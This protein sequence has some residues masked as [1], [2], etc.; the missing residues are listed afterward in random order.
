MSSSP[1]V[2]AV[3]PVAIAKKSAV[4]KAKPTHPSF[5]IMITEGIRKMAD[6]TGSSKQ[7]ISKFI[8]SNYQVDLSNKLMSKH[9]RL[10][11]VA[12]A[13]SGHF[14][15][16]KGTGASGSFK[17][18]DA[19]KSAAKKEKEATKPKKEAATATKKVIKKKPTAVASI[20]KFVKVKVVVV[21][22][23]VTKVVAKKPA[24]DAKPKKNIRK[25]VVVKAPL[26]KVV[27]PAAALPPVQP[28]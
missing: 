10:A 12:G 13:Q 17:I 8:S 7:A 15:Q 14:K 23:K 5:A 3:A 26:K 16:V 21:A 22:K 18:G 28:W 6:K 2:L 1:V 20:S 27:V 25:P 19:T 9:F 4:P 24:A 11:L